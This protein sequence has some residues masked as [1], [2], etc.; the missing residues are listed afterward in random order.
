[1]VIRR[2]LR[3]AA[4]VQIGVEALHILQTN[5]VQLHGPECRVNAKPKQLF[6]TT[7]TALA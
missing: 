4:L 6:V 5:R 3:Q 2:S 7:P 1:V